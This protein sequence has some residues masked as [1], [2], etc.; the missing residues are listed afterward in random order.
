MA[1]VLAGITI[2]LVLAWGATALAHRASA[3]WRHAIWT[4]ALAAVLLLAPLRWRMPQHAIA[5]VFAVSA[6]VTVS[7][8][9]EIGPAP[10]VTLAELLPLVWAFGSFVM[11]LR[12]VGASVRLRSIV[13]GA[14]G[15]GLIRVSSRIRG[16]LVAGVL[17]PVILLPESSEKRG[18]PRAAKRCWR[19]RPP[20]SAATTRPF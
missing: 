17:R 20:T 8:A 4:C 6:D 13:R 18:R 7:A 2:V 1:S 14:R 10:R 19:M 9:P 16:P 3:A 15:D 5:P 12:L 11:I